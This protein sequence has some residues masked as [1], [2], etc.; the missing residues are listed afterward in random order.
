MTLSWSTSGSG[1][2][3]DPA[4]LNPVYTRSATDLTEVTLTL[5]GTKLN[6]CP[7]TL[8]DAMTL[9][10]AG[11]PSADAGADRDLCSGTATVTLSDAS[12]TN[13]TISW[14]TSGNGTFSDPSIAT[15]VYTFG[16]SD[17]GPVTLTITVTSVSCG[18][19]SDNLTIT[20][21][22]EPVADAGTGGSVCRTETGFQVAGASHAGGT[23]TWSTSGNGT[24]SDNTA[25]N[26]YYT[27]GTA[28]YASGSATL[29]MTVTGG[30]TC[31]TVTSSAT[32]AINALPEPE[33]TSQQQI[34]CNGLTDGAVQ[35]TA[36]GGL[37][38]YTYSINGGPFQASGD[39]TGLAAGTYA[40]EVM[41]ANGC[42]AG[43]T[44]EIAEPMPFTA[45]IDGTDDVTCHGSSDGAIYATLSGGTEP[46]NISWAGPDGFTASTADITGLEAGTY[47]LTVSD[48]NN[49]VTLSFIEVITQPDAIEII[50]AVISDNNGHGVTC[51]GSE[52][53]SITVTIQGGTPPLVLEWTGPAG[54][55]SDQPSI[56]MLGAGEYTLTITDA[57]G[58]TFTT[59]YT[60]TAP[61]ALDISA[62]TADAS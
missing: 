43:T 16:S 1:T 14:T 40:F 47:T 59:D 27:F 35:L 18:T 6:G 3:S 41:D 8:T 58:C 36:S 49:C 51:P 26:P 54:F 11:V 32:V 45:L 21:T 33:V 39:F 38:P 15:P 60:L 7:E 19:V 17:S 24:F 28:D 42:T 37:A 13:G 9:T 52:D 12:A 4:A 31:G 56:S 46:Y 23:V 57:A 20:F 30:G 34:T 22:P 50:S 2:F 10:F 25:D 61:E 48:R 5:T 55:T 44:V 62:V 53:G 29:T